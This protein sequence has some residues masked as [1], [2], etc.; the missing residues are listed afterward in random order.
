M[1]LLTESSGSPI[2]RPISSGGTHVLWWFPGS[3]LGLFGRGAHDVE[4]EA[5]DKVLRPS[6]WQVPSKTSLP[7]ITVVDCL[8]V[9][10]A[11]PLIFFLYVCIPWVYVSV[12]QDV[13]IIDPLACI[14]AQVDGNTL[15]VINHYR[16][17]ITCFPLESLSSIHREQY[18]TFLSDILHT[19]EKE[20]KIVHD[21]AHAIFSI[22]NV[23]EEPSTAAGLANMDHRLCEQVCKYRICVLLHV[24]GA[25]F[26]SFIYECSF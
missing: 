8:K 2:A 11:A 24:Q 26:F 22:V 4:R 6:D 25:L 19:R 14:P 16:H 10:G 23:E 7:D 5:L 21:E 20:N 18:D 9:W 13:Y 1:P 3:R 15:L 12:A 17:Q